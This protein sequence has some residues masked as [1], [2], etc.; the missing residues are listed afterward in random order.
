M[1]AHNWL[2]EGTYSLHLL[3]SF[4]PVDDNK[5]ELNKQTYQTDTRI[6]KVGESTNLFFIKCQGEV[7]SVQNSNVEFVVNFWRYRTSGY[8]QRDSKL[9]NQKTTP[10]VTDHLPHHSGLVLAT[11]SRHVRGI[12]I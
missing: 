4:S 6:N 3:F 1:N 12:A 8:R 2:R 7:S 5:S 11:N 9:R 10:G